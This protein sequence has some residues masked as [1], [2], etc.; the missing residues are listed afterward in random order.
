MGCM[1][2]QDA[3]LPIGCLSTHRMLVYP[4]DVCLPIGCLPTHW[5]KVYP[6][7]ESLPI[8]RKSTH[9]KK[10]YPSEERPPIGRKS[11]NLKKGTHLKQVYPLEESL[12]I[13]RKSAH[14]KKVWRAR[15]DRARARAKK[16]TC[17]RLELCQAP[18]PLRPGMTQT[19]AGNPLTPIKRALRVTYCIAYGTCYGNLDS[20]VYNIFL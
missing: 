3:C 10:A 8:S 2:T 16:R 17:Q 14:W 18:V 7:E 12:P 20:V 1:S 6:S 13:R 15:W 9:L 5:K 11:T 19:H 4:L